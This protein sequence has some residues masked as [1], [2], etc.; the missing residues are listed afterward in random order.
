L[1]FSGSLKLSVNKSMNI[2]IAPDSFKESLS[3]SAVA[4]AIRSGFAEIFPDANYVCLPMA[5]G[6]EGTTASLVAATKGELYTSEVM[7]P[8]GEKVTASWGILGNQHSAIIETA[9]AGGLHLVPKCRRNP[10]L[11]TSFGTGELIK[12]A[13]DHGVKHIILGLGGSATNDAGAGLLQALGAKLLDRD[14]QPLSVGGGG[15]SELHSI[16]ISELDPRLAGVKFAAACDV[17][18]PL[19]GP[20]GASYTYA[21]QKGATPE[22]VA[23]LDKNLAHFAEIIFQTNGCS[24]S[25]V[26]G[27]GAAGGIGAVLLAFFNAELKPGIE[28][29]LDAVDINR[30][31][32]T[33]D[34]LITGE[35]RI[36]SQSIYGKTPVGVARRAKDFDCQVLA[37]AGCVSDDA[38]VVYEEGIDAM[39]SI[40]RGVV[41]L[42]SALAD[43]EVNLQHCA[44][45]IAKVWLLGAQIRR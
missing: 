10:L 36:D 42:E 14:K 22:M 1:L 32:A 28:I 15:L 9:E 40:V 39:F 7:G 29:V 37:I 44:R 34:L 45:N 19:T 12:A 16:D 38:D 27:A 3:A 24:V 41:S 2:L 5:D 26:S 6:G 20:A 18:N 33:T 30:Y 4:Q 25:Q 11:T 8:L 13:L 31:L 21:V 35:G 43:A 23:Q 17:N